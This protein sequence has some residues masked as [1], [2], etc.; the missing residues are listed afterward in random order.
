M[1]PPVSHSLLGTQRGGGDGHTLVPRELW[2]ALHQAP[3]KGWLSSPVP[4]SAGLRMAGLVSA[5]CGQQSRALPEASRALLP[6]LR[7][8][9]CPLE[10]RCTVLPAFVHTLSSGGGGV[11]RLWVVPGFF[12]DFLGR[13][14]ALSAQ[15]RSG[16]LHPQL[17]AL[18]GGAQCDLRLLGWIISLSLHA[19]GC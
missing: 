10:P 14:Q 13:G 4:G 1:L 15:P 2:E 9:H 16:S 11:G 8:P 6:A 17:W 18:P 5:A 7:W 12:S 19:L 3:S